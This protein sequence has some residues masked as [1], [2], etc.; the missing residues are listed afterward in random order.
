[1]G[2]V[3]IV[4]A[5]SLRGTEGVNVSKESADIGRFLSE[6]VRSRNRKY[7]Q[8]WDNNRRGSER[9]K[10]IAER[11]IARGTVEKGLERGYFYRKMN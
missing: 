6:F 3:Y 4:D 10:A 1:M 8:H 11:G 7:E 5:G 9:G 2:A